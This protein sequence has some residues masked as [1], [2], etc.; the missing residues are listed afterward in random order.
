[1][2]RK[3]ILAVSAAALLGGC[4]VLPV[5]EPAVGEA[6]AA[7]DTEFMPPTIAICVDGAGYKVRKDADGTVRLPAD[8]RISLYT[9]LVMADYNVTYTCH[10]G[11]SYQFDPTKRYV[12]TVHND[13]RGCAIDLVQENP[14]TPT[15]LAVEPTGF[16][17]L[18][19]PWANPAKA[20]AAPAR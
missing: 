11:A 7:L 17:P 15:G 20:K 13:S 1:M 14:D 8:R 18:C 12:A 4:V 3:L 2:A 6:T 19:N 10:P 9:T 5:Y 16:G